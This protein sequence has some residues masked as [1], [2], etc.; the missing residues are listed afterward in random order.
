MTPLER[1]RSEEMSR[2]SPRWQIYCFPRRLQL[3][4][5][6]GIACNAHAAEYNMVAVFVLD[7]ER[8]RPS[9]GG[10][11]YPQGSGT[12]PN[13]R[14]PMNIPSQPD[15]ELEQRLASLVLD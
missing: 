3:R 12:R 6:A 14:F 4:Y 10:E 9:S 1:S 11:N 13:W 2:G 15:Q 8:E 7:K 5:G